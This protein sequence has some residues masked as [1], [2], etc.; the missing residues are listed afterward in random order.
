MSAFVALQRLLPQHA[1]SRFV[2]SLAAS[3]NHLIKTPFVRAFASAYKVNMAEAARSNLD[4]Y[5]SFND[6]FTR[7]L[8]DDA[9]PLAAG[10]QTILCPADGAVSQLGRIEDGQV[11][12]A[13]GIR[14]RFDTLAAQAAGRGFEGGSFITIYLAPSDYHR[15][16]MPVGGR[17]LRSIAVPGALYSVNSHT[18]AEVPG[19]FARNERLVCEFDT[20]YGRV[21]SIMV[22]AMIVASIETVWEGPASPYLRHEV[23]EHDLELARGAEMGRFLLGSTVILCFE[24][25]RAVLSDDLQP[26]TKVRMGRALGTFSETE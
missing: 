22:G 25:G 8:K 16:H 26:G 19:L 13:K 24:Q 21:L 3:E 7:E 6:F 2:G 1:L 9:R 15:V 14:Y 18:E 17:L 4:D 5:R 23:R 12:Q 10:E 20:P 11:L